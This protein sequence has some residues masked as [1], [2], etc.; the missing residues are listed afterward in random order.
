MPSLTNREIVDRFARALAANDVNEQHALLA[1]DFVETH[2][3]SGER[4]VG[5][6]NRRAII[7]NY[8]GRPEDWRGQTDRV[9]GGED[10]W[11]MTPTFSAL[12]IVGTGDDYTIAGHITYP[13]GDDSHLIQLIELRNAKISTLT[14]YFAPKFDAPAWRSTWVE[15]TP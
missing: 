8:P 14:T 1:D 10:R 3:Q 2:P 11:V 4:I 7:E 15:K 12:R 5:K 9:V 13:G 6:S